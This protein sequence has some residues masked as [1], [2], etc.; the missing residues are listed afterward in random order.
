MINSDSAFL[1]LPCL[2]SILVF[3]GISASFVVSAQAESK[4]QAQLSEL[5]QSQLATISSV[6]SRS[7]V[8]RVDLAAI[9]KISPETTGLTLSIDKKRLEPLPRCLADSGNLFRISSVHPIGILSLQLQG[10]KTANPVSVSRTYYGP[11][12]AAPVD[13]ERPRLVNDLVTSTTKAQTIH[14]FAKRA[15]LLLAS[16]SNSLLIRDARTL[17]LLRSIDGLSLGDASSRAAW[18][19]SEQPLIAAKSRNG[20]TLAVFDPVSGLEVATSAKS[21][22]PAQVVSNPQGAC[23]ATTSE[24]SSAVLVASI[25]LA[26]TIELQ[27]QDMLLWSAVALAWTPDGQ[28]LAVQYAQAGAENSVIVFWDVLKRQSIAKHK[29]SGASP[30]EMGFLGDGR[31][32]LLGSSVGTTVMDVISGSFKSASFLGADAKKSVSKLSTTNEGLLTVRF[33]DE[34]T[35]IFDLS[36][37][38]SNELGQTKQLAKIEKAAQ[39]ALFDLNHIVVLDKDNSLTTRLA[40]DKWNRSTQAVK[41]SGAYINVA[42]SRF[43]AELPQDRKV[44]IAGLRKS[45]T[46]HF[47]DVWDNDSSQ[48]STLALDQKSEEDLDS[49]LV[50]KGKSSFAVI[51]GHGGFYWIEAEP[52][53]RTIWTPL[54]KQDLV[55]LS[56]GVGR[57]VI[58]ATLPAGQY[59]ALRDFTLET[60]AE[61]KKFLRELNQFSKASPVSLWYVAGPETAPK[62]LATVQ[63][64]PFNISGPDNSGRFAIAYLSGSTEIRNADGSIF[65]SNLAAVLGTLTPQQTSIELSDTGKY[66]LVSDSQVLRLIRVNDGV[67]LN[68]QRLPSG[69][70]FKTIAWKPQAEQFVVQSDKGFAWLFDADQLD[71]AKQR[72]QEIVIGPRQRAVGLHPNGRLLFVQTG[73]N[74]TDLLDVRGKT[75]ARFEHEIGSVEALFSA[76]KKTLFLRASDKLAQFNLDQFLNDPAISDSSNLPELSSKPQRIFELPKPLSAPD[77]NWIWLDHQLA[78]FVHL[79][80]RGELT[81]ID[82]LTGQLKAKYTIRA[83]ANDTLVSAVSAD[84]NAGHIVLGYL[85]GA[86]TVFDWRKGVVVTYWNSGE[87]VQSVAIHAKTV[88]TTGYGSP[89]SIWR[90]EAKSVQLIKRLNSTTVGKYKQASARFSADG[91]TLMLEEFVTVFETDMPSTIS[92]RITLVDVGSD[93]IRAHVTS[94]SVLR[95]GSS[96]G[97]AI[98]SDALSELELGLRGVLSEDFQLLLTRRDPGRMNLSK[99]ASVAPVAITKSLPALSATFFRDDR[100]IGLDGSG[101]IQI[102]TTNPAL[103]DLRIAWIDE[104]RWVV[105]DQMGRFDGNDLENLDGLH[106][107]VFDRPTDPI[108]IE[109]FLSDYYEPQLLAK[110]LLGARLQPVANIGSILRL[111]PLVTIDS[112][113]ATN[114]GRT[115]SI[116]VS[117]TEQVSE[118]IINSGKTDLRI[119]RDGQLIK[120]FDL[121]SSLVSSANPHKQTFE[122]KDIALPSAAKGA[123]SQF[124]AYAFNRDKVKSVSAI[125]SLSIA[126]RLRALKPRAWVLSVGVNSH[127]NPIWNLSFSVNDAKAMNQLLVKSLRDAG[128]YQVVESILLTSEGGTLLTREA[129]SQALRDLSSQSTNLSRPSPD[130]LVIITFAGHGVRNNAGEFFLVPGDIRLGPNDVQLADFDKQTISGQY[131]SELLEPIDAGQIFLIIDACQSAAAVESPT[132][133][134]GPLGSR[135]LGQLAFDKGMRVLAGSQSSGFAI[136]SSRLQHGALTYAFVREG[137]EQRLASSTSPGGVLSL[138]S[139]LKY[140]VGRVPRLIVDLSQNKI[141]GAQRVGERMTQLPVQQPAIYDFSRKTV[142]VYLGETAPRAAQ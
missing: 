28:K 129:V 122:I 1:K 52:E 60:L 133:K 55:T 73:P 3:V 87:S 37:L 26:Y 75:L 105:I 6:F 102:N 126:P 141:R 137:I 71:M 15:G 58:V 19:D 24:F 7:G 16:N 100:W 118:R 116:K 35:K 97:S 88:A 17:K 70:Q 81:L 82:L 66:V 54:P 42:S 90:V 127:K 22:E 44:W 142:P 94:R 108:P 11:L 89:V 79:S 91:S 20:L 140:T 136:E 23:V 53:I 109:A 119:F 39:V 76:D 10:E 62:L 72:S 115:A 41:P 80:D 117:V 5:A 113:V 130:D 21:V 107:I 32:L 120:R 112:L 93:E 68:A 110:S 36:G 40:K 49:I 50:S 128:N 33:S 2:Q 92:H 27:P 12:W 69:Q 123:S 48:P 125:Q 121:I 103:N 96:K 106:W 61:D 85:D 134:P 56:S 47:I 78:A 74:R 65:N 51:T 139:V 114:E 67:V 138:Q 14:G 131:L 86:V 111:Q 9:R 18:L 83:Q 43:N 8:A 31:R 34:I 135:G 101:A 59:K 45:E 25:D 98:G 29:V 63:D 64:V 84:T 99:M 46:T 57:G 95:S 124:S 77:K 38:G 13:Q 132:F 30:L 4:E 104:K